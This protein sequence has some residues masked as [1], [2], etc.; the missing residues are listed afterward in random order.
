MN[1]TEAPSV[2]S[3]VLC[4]LVFGG[5]FFAGDIAGWIMERK[6]T[7]RW[8][9]IA[10]E[11]G[12]H[13]HGQRNRWPALSDFLLPKLMLPEHDSS[14]FRYGEALKAF[15]GRTLGFDVTIADFAVWNHYA[16]P[17]LV[18]RASIAVFQK[19]GA[20]IP[21]TMVAVKDRS[22]LLDGFRLNRSLREYR[23]P[24]DKG[25]SSQFVFFGEF[26]RTPWAFTSELRDL[27][28][29]FE[30][31]IDCLYMGRREMVLVCNERQ[32]ERFPDLVEF[33]VTVMRNL[34]DDTLSGQ[35]LAETDE[36][37]YPMPDAFCGSILS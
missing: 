7:Q 1:T 12:F 9:T 13:F 22:M 26:G 4:V 14:P 25:F 18:F 30:K 10:G 21:R 24:N 23:F 27:F 37:C 32:P 15:W 20:V 6:W 28:V 36:G 16:Y 3:A 33:G 11:M 31:E 34:A 17:P 19:Q 29:R 8:K 2:L 35:P 5:S